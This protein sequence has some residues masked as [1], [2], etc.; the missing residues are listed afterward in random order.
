MGNKY[1][2]AVEAA[3]AEKNYFAHIEKLRGSALPDSVDEKG[4]GGKNDS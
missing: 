4:R 1:N 3:K 2:N